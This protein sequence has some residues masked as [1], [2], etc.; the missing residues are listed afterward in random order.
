MALLD[1]PII[2][3]SNISHPERMLATTATHYPIKV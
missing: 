3:E 1:L 2:L